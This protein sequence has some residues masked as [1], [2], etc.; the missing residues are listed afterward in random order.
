MSNLSKKEILE[1]YKKVIKESYVSHSYTWYEAD[2]KSKS[3]KVLGTD[4]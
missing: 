1:L 3:K 4:I 2:F